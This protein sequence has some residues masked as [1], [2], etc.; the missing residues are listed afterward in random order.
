MIFSS[1]QRATRNEGV[2]LPG[3]VELGPAS[4]CLGEL[5]PA[6]ARLDALLSRATALAQKEY[7]PGAS[8]DRF[9][10]LHI[11]DEDVSR[12]LARRAATPIL[13]TNRVTFEEQV[14]RSADE[15][16]R[17]AWLQQTF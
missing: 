9:R 12:L 6:L 11:S 13:C 4:S 1:H 16:S 7:G 5:V 14:R 10:G 15:L 17:F 3:K 8:A 2:T